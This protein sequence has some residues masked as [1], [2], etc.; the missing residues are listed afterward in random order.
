MQQKNKLTNERSHGW[1]N[2]FKLFKTVNI[3]VRRTHM[4]G[5]SLWDLL[6]FHSVSH[7]DGDTCLLHHLSVYHASCWEHSSLSLLL[8]LKDRIRHG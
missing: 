3:H 5:V 7:P 6:Y 1:P 2:E 4:H 8:L